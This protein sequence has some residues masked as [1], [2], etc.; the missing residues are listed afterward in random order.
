MHIAGLLVN[1]L[2]KWSRFKGRDLNFHSRSI[3]T[4][5][6]PLAVWRPIWDQ[7]VKQFG[8]YEFTADEIITILREAIHP[9]LRHLQPGGV[10]FRSRQTETLKAHYRRGGDVSAD[11]G[12]RR[13]IIS[14]A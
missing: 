12:P 6:R 10:D 1:D 11:R 8:S 7:K 9:T 3:E 5:D 4:F 2:D 14:L 13:L